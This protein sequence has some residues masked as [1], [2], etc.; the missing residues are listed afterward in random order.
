MYKETDWLTVEINRR[1][2]RLAELSSIFPAKLK[3]QVRS[4][5]KFSHRFVRVS[6]LVF[7]GARAQM[8]G[9]VGFC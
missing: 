9:Y 6:I 2:E 3:I 4:A 7:A 1:G 8:S 5:F